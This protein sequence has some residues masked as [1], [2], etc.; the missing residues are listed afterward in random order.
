MKKSCYILLI[1][2]TLSFGVAGCIHQ[3]TTS[4]LTRAESMQG[5]ST[6]SMLFYLQQ[7]RQPEKLTGTTQANYC[8]LL[9]KA[10]LW[11]TG[12]P[13]DSLLQV[14]IPTFLE[15]KDTVQWIKARMEQANGYLYTQQ[16]TLAIQQVNRIR[17][18]IPMLNDSLKIQLYGIARVAYIRKGLYPQA[19]QMADSSLMMKHILN[20]TLSFYHATRMRLE[21]LKYMNRNDEFVNESEALMLK[22]KA[23]TRYSSFNYHIAGSLAT[24]YLN[25]KDFKNAL[26][27]NDLLKQ[28]QRSRYDVPYHQLLR[29]RTYA[30]LN[31]TDSA[32]VYYTLASNSLSSHVAAEASIS[33]YQ[34]INAK[35]YPEQAYYA[36]LKG[37]EIEQNMVNELNSLIGS[38]KYNETKLQNELYQLRLRQ[39][40]KELWMMGTAVVLLF[41]AL[42]GLL[43]YQREKKKRLL[44]EQHLQR[45]QAEEKARQLQHE[46]LLLH[47][48]SELSA[49]REKEARLRNKE[50]ELRE[51]IFRRISFFHKLPSLHIDNTSEESLPSRKIELTDAE[52]REVRLAVNDGFDH[53]TTRLQQVYPQLTEKEIDFCCLVKINVNMQDLSDIY[54]VGKAAITKRKYRIKKEKLGIT[55]ENTNLDQILQSL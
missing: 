30:A 28:Y 38:R 21:I 29:G 36:A 4:L 53:F 1:L 27:Y 26:R 6:D 32:R 20:D 54:C 3:S 22:L 33:L 10:T 23:S 15:A 46:N 2:I 12:K 41:M 55:D 43:F 5:I 35:E 44:S 13:K 45:E 48:E 31:N 9:Y 51:A 34:L 7:I 8:F 40:A 37:N 50:H 42:I 47:K 52:W 16:P 25:H 39:Q 14:C 49:L 17:Q 24:F 11:G 18:E 19:L